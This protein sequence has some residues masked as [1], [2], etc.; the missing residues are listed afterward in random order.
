MVVEV[1]KILTLNAAFKPCISITPVHP[2]INIDKV[3]DTE[4][5][6][7]LFLYKIKNRTI[8]DT[9]KDLSLKAFDWTFF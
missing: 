8:R 9:L 4:H 2:S 7:Y 6:F 3:S 1:N 5:C